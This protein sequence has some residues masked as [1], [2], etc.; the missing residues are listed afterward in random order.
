MQ[1]DHSHPEQLQ[2]AVRISRRDKFRAWPQTDQAP[3]VLHQSRVHCLHSYTVRTDKHTVFRLLRRGCRVTSLGVP[4]AQSVRGMTEQ[5]LTESPGPR[6]IEILRLGDGV[7]RGHFTNPRNRLW[8]HI[9]RV[10]IHQTC[11]ANAL[12]ILARGVGYEF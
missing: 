7:S 9:A 11:F 4:H 6:K 5:R 10:W 1:I 3:Y 2:T 8:R 12:K